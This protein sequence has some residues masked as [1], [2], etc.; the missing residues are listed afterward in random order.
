MKKQ[1]DTLSIIKERIENESKHGDKAKACRRAGISP[2][3]YESGIKKSIY[4][5]LT[6]GEEAVLLAH[7]AILDERKKER[8]KISRAICAQ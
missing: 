7:I 4:D 6:D 3:T 2:T 5:D 8:D 1:T